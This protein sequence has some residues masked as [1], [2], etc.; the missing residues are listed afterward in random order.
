MS[1]KQPK[2]IRLN[3]IITAAIEEFLEKGYDGASVNT[4]ARRAGVSKGGFY[5]HFL[6]KEELLMEANRKL[7]EPVILMAEKAYAAESARDGLRLYIEEY[8]RYWTGHPKELGFFFMSMSK[9]FES[10][11]LM[12]YYKEYMEAATGFFISLL[13]KAAAVGEL[14][15]DDPEAYG[16]ALMG[17]LDGVLSYAMLWQD[18]ETDPLIRRF[19]RI[20]IDRE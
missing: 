17:S 15:I 7:S 16:I 3:A 4:I 1:L 11:R 8:I 9:A 14:K 20:W 18:K 19:I 13:Q 10:E 12:Q 2:E 6:N 5:H